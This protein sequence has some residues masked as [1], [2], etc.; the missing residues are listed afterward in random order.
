M[1]G[2]EIIDQ[3]I[4]T[5]N[6]SEILGFSEL[7]SLIAGPRASR[8]GFEKQLRQVPRQMVDEG[9]KTGRT[10]LSWA[11]ELGDLYLVERLIARGADPNKADCAGYIP[12]FYC[13]LKPELFRG[14]LDAGTNVNHVCRRGLTIMTF[15]SFLHDDPD[16]FELL[17][18]YGANIHLPFPRIEYAL[19]HYAVIY[20]HPRTV[21]WLLEKGPDLET[22]ADDGATPFQLAVERPECVNTARRLLDM[23]ADHKVVNRYGE[24]LLHYVARRGDL[25]TLAILQR[26]GL[27]G[28]DLGLKGHRG[29]TYYDYDPNGKTALEIAEYRRDNNEAWAREQQFVPP[30]PD[31]GKWFA[32]F[33]ALVDSIETRNAIEPSGDFG[34]GLGGAQEGL[35]DSPHQEREKSNAD[36][37]HLPVLPGSYLDK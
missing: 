11:A 7:H 23:S 33:K 30:D 32:S 13:A 6:P 10:A 2:C 4:N 31:P 37:E 14:L 27:S 24:G 15:L 22:Y 29:Y 28:I 9:D 21:L 34:G 35:G 12:L 5:S 18:S 26:V 17:W 25:E 36:K 20:E 3:I 19:L 8:T 16:L 1:P